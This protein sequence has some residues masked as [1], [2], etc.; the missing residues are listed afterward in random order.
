[1][2]NTK[3]SFFRRPSDAVPAAPSSLDRTD[4]TPEAEAQAEATTSRGPFTRPTQHAERKPRADDRERRPYT[5]RPGRGDERPYPARAPRGERPDFRRQGKD[6]PQE[7]KEAPENVIYGIHPLREALEAGDPIEKIYLRR[8][9][10]IQAV[11]GAGDAIREIEELAIERG[12]SVQWVPVEKLD[13]LTRRN[14]HQGVVGVVPP[15]EYTEIA[16]ILEKSPKLL[17]VLD[18]VTDV[19]NFGAIARS[20]ECAGV[21][22]IVIGAKNCA[23]INGEAM[24]SSAGALGRIAVARVGSLR[25]ALRTIQLADIQ[26]VAATEKGS[27]SLFKASLTAPCAIIMGSEERGISPDTLKLCDQ[28][29]N[30][31]LR[32][33]IESLNVSAAAAVLLF[34]VL[35]QRNS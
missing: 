23:P 35:R 27:T 9:E 8:V 13:R 34:E 29:V 18:G 10:M 24:K 25:N 12:V 22:A 28:M 2:D 5:P 21:D 3:K 32:G 31:P 26:L 6:Q 14:N 15:I 19:R 33:S 11:K 20:A 7:Q 30:I 16:E 1:M 4:W 17:L